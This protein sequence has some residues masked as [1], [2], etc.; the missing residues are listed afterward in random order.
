MDIAW[1]FNLAHGSLESLPCSGSQQED[2]KQSSGF[3][4]CLTLQIANTRGSAMVAWDAPSVADG[5]RRDE[6]CIPYKSANNARSLSPK[7]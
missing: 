1:G 6:P 5:L 7:P 4:D 3:S 2:Y